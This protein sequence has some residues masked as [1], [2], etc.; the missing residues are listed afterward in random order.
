MNFWFSFLVSLISGLYTSLWGAFKDSPYEG[1][2]RPTFPRSIYFHAVI[3]GALWV[4][5]FFRESFRSLSLF[6]IFFA[7]MGLER[8]L[9]EL[10]KGFFRTED[11]S[12]YAVPSRFTFFGRPVSSESLRLISGA[13]LVS[14]VFAL[15]FLST[16]IVDFPVFAVVA[17][18]TGMLVS[19]GGAYKDAPFEGFAPL[20][21]FRSAA[22]LTICSPLFFYSNNPAAPVPLGY[23]IFMNGGLERFL[24]EYY[25]TYVQRTMSGKFRQD[26]PRMTRYIE[27]REKYHYIA[28]IIIIGLMILYAYELTTL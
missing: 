5:P 1:L 18:S 26:L 24:V 9:A 27:T 14:G 16:P 15:L 19:L 17:F 2:K 4:L 10:Y 11:Q 3:F 23:L 25:K 20:K 13:I 21:F 7:V 6:Q 12:K 22:V 28:W 8:F